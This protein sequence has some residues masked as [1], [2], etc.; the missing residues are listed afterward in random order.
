[1][2]AFNTDSEAKDAASEILTTRTEQKK[3]QFFPVSEG[4]LMTLY[5]LS[6]GLYGIYWFYKNWK[7]QQ[8]LMDKKIYPVLRAIFSI[9]F[10]HALFRRINAQATGLEKKH[11]FN[12]NALATFFVASIVASHI[13]DRLST[14]STAFEGMMS[15]TVIITSLALF[16]LSVYPMLKVQ[17][18]V[19]RIN[20]DMLGYLNHKYSL[21]NIALIVLGIGLWLLIGMGILAESMGLIVP[22]NL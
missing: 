16:C 14:H 6:L 13:L 21:W 12:A 8:P 10:T 3:I 15:S 5:I 17:A 20:G 1:M 22:E 2:T 18:T 11:Q 7:L 4:K 19:N 9:F